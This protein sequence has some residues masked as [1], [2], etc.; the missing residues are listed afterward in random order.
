M[1]Q[2]LLKLPFIL[3]FVN[4]R[5][6]SYSVDHVTSPLSYED[7]LVRPDLFSEATLLTHVKLSFILTSILPS[8]YASSMLQVILPFSVVS[9]TCVDTSVDTF[10]TSFVSVPLPFVN[11]PYGMNKHSK[12]MC[13]IVSPLSFV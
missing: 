9:S 3:S 2:V 1:H 13:P 11:V 10:S 8:F 6:T 5:L 4:P 7:G 12:P